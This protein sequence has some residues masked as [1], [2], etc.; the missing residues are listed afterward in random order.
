[1]ID[2]TLPI[3]CITVFVL[4]SLINAL[5][6]VLNSISW[7]TGSR[8]LLLPIIHPPT[9]HFTCTRSV[10]TSSLFSG[11]GKFY[12]APARFSSSNAPST[13]FLP[14]S[15]SASSSARFSPICGIRPNARKK[16]SAASA[17]PMMKMSRNPFWY[18]G[19]S[20]L[21]MCSACSSLCFDR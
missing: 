8:C 19:I 7:F 14:S 10:N 5:I 21:L 12:G 2:T 17:A 4:L 18:A 11:N 13:R 20:T 3:S 15:F 9:V 1:M 16:A 6:L